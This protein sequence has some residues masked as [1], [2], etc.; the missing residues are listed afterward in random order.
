MTHKKAGAFVPRPNWKDIAELSGIVAIVASL[1]FVG[2]QLQQEQEIAIV[3]TY[4]AL[5]ESTANLADL[6]ERNAEIWRKGLDGEELSSADKIKFLTLA[7]A[8][9]IHLSNVHIRWRRIG[10]GNPDQVA[11]NYAYA[12]YIYPGLRQARA[13]NTRLLPDPDLPSGVFYSSL[14]MQRAV[15]SFLEDFDEA[16]TPIPAQKSYVFW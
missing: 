9:E 1:I 5:A 12:L 2:L 14:L 7:S 3:D 13:E 4:G 15:D 16:A 10:P 6:A 11:R 8:V